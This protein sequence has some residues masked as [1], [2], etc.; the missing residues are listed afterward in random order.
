MSETKAIL[1]FDQLG[2][3]SYHL[4]RLHKLGITVPT[5]IQALAIPLAIKRKDLIGIA[6]TGTGKTLA[7][8]LPMLM[9]L[10]KMKQG[11]VLAP[12]RE[13]ALQIEATYKKLGGRTAVLIGAAPMNRQVAAIRTNPQVIVATPGRLLD[14][15]QQGTLTLKH[16]GIVVLD[17]ADRMLDMGFAPT[18]KRILAMAPKQRQTML[19]SA[20]MPAEIE[21]LARQF[22]IDPE[23]VSVERQGTTSELIEQEL[24]V[25]EK[26]NK[27]D[28]LEDILTRETGSVLIF[29][30]TRHGARKLTRSMRDVGHSAAEIHS[31]RTLSQRRLA[32]EGFKEGVYRILIATDI[33]SRGIDVKDIKLVVNFDL[34]DNPEDYVHRIGRTGRAGS[35][36]RAVTFASPDQ[37]KDLMDI[38]RLI[39]LEIPLSESSPLEMKRPPLKKKPTDAEEPRPVTQAV[40]A[41]PRSESPT[42]SAKPERTEERPRRPQERSAP[43]P[44][45]PYSGPGRPSQGQRPYNDRPAE[46]F[47]RPERG[48]PKPAEASN[49][50]PGNFNDRPARPYGSNPAGGKP[51][52]KQFAKSID[53]PW[54]SKPQPEGAATP[55]WKKRT[56]KPHHS[57]TSKPHATP[58]S[59]SGKNFG[60]RPKF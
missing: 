4:Q 58:K 48:G 49:Q 34:P 42:V 37:R 31:D 44:Q 32:L 14:H 52:G 3:E 15:L 30:R 10:G 28:L 57:G 8:S 17:E 38:E 21:Q 43:R 45:K 46:R 50:R 51:K 12:T 26:A 23:K 47:S 1:A 33:A 16:M 5:P 55:V 9:T 24:Y 19:F 60:R 53:K 54:V 11:L 25:V 6:Q 13:L 41:K 36:G 22:M 20:T 18:I 29:A 2:I 56:G 39:Q 59:N 35:E 7:F 27:V 40:V